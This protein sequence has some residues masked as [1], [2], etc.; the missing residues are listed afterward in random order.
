MRIDEKYG[1]LR[2]VEDE[3][4]DKDGTCL[5]PDQVCEIDHNSIKNEK[6]KTLIIDKLGSNDLYKGNIGCFAIS[7]LPNLQRLIIKQKPHFF[8]TYNLSNCPQ[9]SEFNYLGK[10]WNVFQPTATLNT[11][12]ADAAQPSS[13]IDYNGCSYSVYYC[14]PFDDSFIKQNTSNKNKYVAVSENRYAIG[15]G[16]SRFGAAINAAYKSFVR[17][18]GHGIGNSEFAPRTEDTIA[19][20]NL[21]KGLSEE[22]V[23]DI[24]TAV[25]FFQIVLNENYKAD[26]CCEDYLVQMGI[27]NSNKQWTTKRI[28][29]KEFICRAANVNVAEVFWRTFHALQALNGPEKAIFPVDIKKC[30]E[31]GVR[32]NCNANIRG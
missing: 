13:K 6:V 20:L 3:D 29:M 5:I 10:T 25:L 8:H 26:Y 12:L 22:S 30:R 24:E 27:L 14:R 11:Y 17:K 28:L 16:D 9:L 18:D 1:V 23:L 15:I 19:R 7:G 31:C 2:K 4:I 21:F 32:N